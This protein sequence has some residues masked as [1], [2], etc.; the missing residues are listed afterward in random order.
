MAPAAD[1]LLYAYY[2]D[3]F[4]G[5]T[6]VLESLAQAGVASVLFLRM[7]TAQALERFRH[8]RAIGIA[9]QSR[10]QSP[11]WMQANLPDILQALRALHPAVVHY[12]V[13]STFDSSPTHGSIGCALEIG[14]TIFQQRCTLVVPAA[15]HLG[16]YVL[17]G[18]LYATAGD[19]LYRIDLH[20]TM[21]RH[22]VTPML[23]PDL[24]KHLAR[25]TALPLRLLDV[26][27]LRDKHPA[28]ALAGCDLEEAC[29]IVLDGVD[30]ATSRATSRLLMAMSGPEPCF[31]VGSSGVTEALVAMWREQGWL[32][33]VAATARQ[34]TAAEPLLVVSGSCSPVTERQ[35]VWAR[36]NGFVPVAAEGARLCDPASCDAE[37]ARLELLARP[38]LQRGASV[39]LYTAL[40]PL[41]PGAAPAPHR[42]GQALGRVT[43]RLLQQCGGLTRVVLCGGDTASHA[44]PQLPVSAL[45][46]LAPLAPG[47]PLCRAYGED[48]F[49][50]VELVLKGGQI[51]AEDF[52][53]LARAGGAA[54]G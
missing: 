18:K 47:A 4:T 21:S 9:G 6:D 25:Q 42:L 14:Q 20:P 38:A 48:G 40:G 1:Q 46:W 39:V 26:L 36:A 15:P 43:H 5:S 3:D 51:G 24:C 8:C 52:F 45:Q 12:K 2:G 50:D 44:V 7:P 19:A 27:A 13:C 17:F 34:A 49:R 41:Q 16:R 28:E 53:A 32:P 35:I 11:A 10:S 23:E 30:D 54:S 31:V 33:P 37:S 29:A 22:P